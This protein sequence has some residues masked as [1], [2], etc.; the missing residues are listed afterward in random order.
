[1]L[2]VMSAALAVAANAKE[3]I[4]PVKWDS[5]G[6]FTTELAIAPKKFKELCVSLKKGETIKWTFDA[7]GPMDFNVHYHQGSDTIY[8]ARQSSIVTGKGELAIPADQDYCWMWQ[9]GETARR[10]SVKLLK[11]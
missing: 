9:S 7:D 10:L 6:G 1:M 2:C 3:H 11:G 4:V 8:P 5:S